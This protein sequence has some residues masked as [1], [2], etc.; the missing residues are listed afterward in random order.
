M[1]DNELNPWIVQE[2]KQV[3]Q[4]PNGDILARSKGLKNILSHQG[5]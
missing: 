2:A 4:V 3:E 1:G 5:T